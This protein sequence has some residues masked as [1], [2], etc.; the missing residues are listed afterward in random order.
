MRGRLIA[1]IVAGALPPA[2]SGRGSSAT[3]SLQLVDQHPNVTLSPQYPAAFAVADGQAVSNLR[4]VATG[5]FSSEM[6]LSVPGYTG[7]ASSACDPARVTPTAS[8]G[9]VASQCLVARYMTTGGIDAVIRYE[10]AHT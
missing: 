2:L 7:P 3:Y 4:P 8:G 9:A 1:A 5:G 6:T 10:G